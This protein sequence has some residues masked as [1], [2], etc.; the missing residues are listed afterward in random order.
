MACPRKPCD[1]GSILSPSVY[2]C[3]IF[4]KWCFCASSACSGATATTDS[5]P[6]SCSTKR[7]TCSVLFRG[8]AAFSFGPNDDFA[9][10]GYGEGHV[11][12]AWSTGIC[13]CSSI[14]SSACFSNFFLR[15]S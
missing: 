11:S 15:S 9:Y 2:G 7:C 8:E 1:F 6:A 12:P 5:K 4:S 14:C 10:A 13:F 3:V